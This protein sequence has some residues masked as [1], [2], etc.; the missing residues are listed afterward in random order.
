MGIP[1]AEPPAAVP[2]L[3]AS[4]PEGSASEP[5]VE[6]PEEEDDPMKA[7]EEAVKKDGGKK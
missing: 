1:E 2:E 7:L 6:K 4:A 3:G 5:E